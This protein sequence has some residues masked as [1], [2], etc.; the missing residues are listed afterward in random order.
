M[1]DLGQAE[2][3]KYF[4]L[5]FSP[6]DLLPLSSIV[7]NTEAHPFPRF[8]LAPLFSTGWTR[9]KLNNT[10]SPLSTQTVIS[11]EQEEHAVGGARN[12]KGSRRL[13][14][15]DQERRKKEEEVRAEVKTIA[16]A[17]GSAKEV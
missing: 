13:E 14:I 4:Y 3:L 10:H 9:A 8:N 2:T 6:T 1:S 5:L 16:K 7:I 12:E 11:D 17:D 15:L